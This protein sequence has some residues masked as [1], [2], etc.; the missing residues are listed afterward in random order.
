M[1]RYITWDDINERLDALDIDHAEDV[2]Y[3]VPKA[4]MI[5]VGR[6]ASIFT[7]TTNPHKAT[8]FLDDLIDSGKTREF[9]QIH[10]PNTRFIAL[11]D[12]Q[13]LGTNDWFI[14]PWEADHPSGEDT[15]EQNVIRQLQYIGEDPN[16]KGLLETPKRVVKAWDEMF[17]GYNQNPED[18]FK[19]FDEDDPEENQIGGLI[20]LKQIEFFSTC[21]HHLLP[22]Y[23]EA[24]IGYVPNGPVIG[25]SKLARLLDIY[26]RRAQIQERIGEQV[27]SAL[28]K[29]LRPLGA[30]CV[31]EAKHLC[32]ACRGVKKQHSIMGYSS[33]KGIFL[34]KDVAGMAART[35]FMSLIK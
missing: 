25:I 28:M 9:Y 10:Y 3:G 15:V 35:E 27:T 2:V 4:G 14:F 34:D 8:V 1:K 22:F 30:A 13:K 31:I 20:Y 17:A 29:Y 23:G 26:A 16:R 21:E 19:I 5:L 24:H 18:V 12:K 6:L 11:Y 33:M 7:V 32:I